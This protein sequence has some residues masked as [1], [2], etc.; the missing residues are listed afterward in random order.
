MVTINGQA[1]DQ[2]RRNGPP[3]LVR[4]MFVQAVLH[5]KPATQLLLVPK[6]GVKPGNVIWKFTSDMSVLD[7]KR[8][9]PDAANATTDASVKAP[10]PTVTAASGLNES[11]SSPASQ[12]D[13]AK[14]DAGR[15]EVLKDIQVIGPFS[16]NKKTDSG[17]ISEEYWI[18]EVSS[19]QLAVGQFVVTSPLP[20]IRGDGTDGIRVPKEQLGY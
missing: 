3:A 16:V 9:K 15:L 4:G 20:G 11:T 6:L 8:P 2:V 14:W 12:L 13:P 5:A 18:C 1:A 17:E 7:V 10:A 19:E